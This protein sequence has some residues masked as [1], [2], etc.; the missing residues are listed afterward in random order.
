[1]KYIIYIFSV[2]NFMCMNRLY[3]SILMVQDGM[4]ALLYAAKKDMFEVTDIL[5]A[6]DADVNMQERVSAFVLACLQ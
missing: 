5:V 1:M 4:T 3:T 2:L 6:A